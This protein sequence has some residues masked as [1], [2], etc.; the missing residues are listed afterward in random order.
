MLAKEVCKNSWKRSLFLYDERLK[1]ERHSLKLGYAG[2]WGGWFSVF[3]KQQQ[4]TA[5]NNESDEIWVY[6][7]SLVRKSL[8]Y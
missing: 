4:A 8:A 3:N 1:E 2:V 5:L 6:L 7:Q